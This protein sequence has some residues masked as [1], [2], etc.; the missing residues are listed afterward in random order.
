MQEQV[1]ELQLQVPRSPEPAKVSEGEVVQAETAASSTDTR[2]AALECKATS[3]VPRRRWATAGVKAKAA[4]EVLVI[5]DPGQDL[6]DEML[7]VLLK[8][9]TARGLVKCVGV[10]TTLAPSKLRAQLAR[11]TLNILKLRSV[12]VGAG[13]H[14]NAQGSLS[15]MA[16]LEYLAASGETVDG[17]ELMVSALEGAEDASLTL[18]LVASLTDGAWLLGSH[19]ALFKRKVRVLLVAH[20]L[21]SETAPGCCLCRSAACT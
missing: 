15:A 19:E 6:D 8:S 13:S 17:T 20:W 11:G 14:G 18:V 7:L 21:P 10:V 1:A 4:V 5:M 3:P 9:L 16:G 2:P 12:P